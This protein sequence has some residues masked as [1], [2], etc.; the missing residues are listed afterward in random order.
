MKYAVYFLSFDE[1]YQPSDTK[2]CHIIEA[3]S[4][5]QTQQI[6]NILCDKDL[7]LIFYG[8]YDAR[9]IVD[10]VSNFSRRT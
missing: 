8:C 2:P 7:G 4:D 6:A 10:N 3:E 1:E 9:P 5:E